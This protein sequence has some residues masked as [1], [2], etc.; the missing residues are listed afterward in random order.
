MSG[1]K[2]AKKSFFPHLPK[3]GIGEIWKEFNQKEARERALEP[4]RLRIITFTLTFIS[5][6]LGLSFIPLFPQPLPILISFMVAA[7]TYGYPQAGMPIGCGV[8]GLGLIYQLSTMNFISMISYD[9]TVRAVVIVVWLVLFIVPPIFYHRQ[10]AALAI[11]LGLLAAMTLFLDQT[12][13]LA[14]PLILTS[15]VLFKRKSMLTVLYTILIYVPLL[16]MQYLNTILQIVR[17]EWWPGISRTYLM[18]LR[19]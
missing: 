5:M 16:L 2:P 4:R 10:K 12:Y 3:G 11:D 18:S 1:L 13:F 15:W 19:A 17:T 6:G 9:S 8:I 7:V 14:I